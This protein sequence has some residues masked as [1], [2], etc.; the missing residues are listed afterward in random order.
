MGRA[1]GREEDEE[2]PFVLVAVAEWSG[3][4]DGWG[5]REE[6]RKTKRC[7]LFFLQ[8]QLL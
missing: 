7:F 5:E 2:M 4:S 3:A 6:K 8:Q 1:R